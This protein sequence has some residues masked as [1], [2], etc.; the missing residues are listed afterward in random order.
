GFGDPYTAAERLSRSLRAVTGWPLGLVSAEQL[1]DDADPLWAAPV[2]PGQGNALGYLTIGQLR[3]EPPPPPHGGP[4]APACRYVPAEQA[5][6][7]AGSLVELLQELF[8]T[9]TAL[10]SREAELSIGVPV[11]RPTD[12]PMQLAMRLEMVVRGGAEGIGC[13]A[14]GL[15]LLDAATTQLKLRSYWGLP[16]D[17]L[18]DPARPLQGAVGDLEALTGHAVVLENRTLFDYWNVPETCEAA[19][20]VPVST[21]TALLGT[22]WFYSEDPRSFSDREANLA[23]IVAGRLAVELERETLL[24]EAVTSV[25]ERRQFDAAQSLLQMQLP[26]AG[27]QSNTWEVSGWAAPDMTRCSAFYDW[28]PVADGQLG[29]AAG[30]TPASGLAGMLAAQ[31]VRASLRAHAAH[32]TDPAELLSRTNIDLWRGAVGDQFAAALCATFDPDDSAA[33]RLA[34]AG[35]IGVWRLSAG[36]VESVID[37]QVPLG[38]EPTSVYQTTSL[39][40]GPGECLVVASEAVCQQFATGSS[41]DRDFVGVLSRLADTDRETADWLQRAVVELLDAGGL[42]NDPAAGTVVVIRRRELAESDRQ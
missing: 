16:P 15:Y 37:P 2:D 7:L 8:R 17:R 14:A 9:R 41:V 33:V 6:E 23:E 38:V 5:T 32:E 42:A 13:H 1:A 20:C 35:S 27:P 22:L 26:A 25:D 10:A 11:A 24:S 39:R 12:T 3:D 30:E 34:V 18:A 21:A 40:V 4:D 19:L 36:G 31:S 28:F 29:V